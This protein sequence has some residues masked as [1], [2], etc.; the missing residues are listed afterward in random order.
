MTQSAGPAL[1]HL[2]HHLSGRLL[3]AHCL[4]AAV[5][6]CACTVVHANSGA[7][8]CAVPGVLTNYNLG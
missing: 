4:T 1:L 8:A 6:E 3:S 5:T 7:L 2:L